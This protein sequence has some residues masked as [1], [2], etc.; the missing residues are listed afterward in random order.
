MSIHTVTLNKFLKTICIICICINDCCKI[1]ADF[2]LVSKF[3]FIFVPTK[4]THV[5]A[6]AVKDID[7]ILRPT[8]PFVGPVKG[9]GVYERYYSVTSNFAT[10]N[11]HTGTNGNSKRLR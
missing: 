8:M 5:W 4:P 6:R 7:G 1:L 9:K 3:I 2:L 11:L 10:L